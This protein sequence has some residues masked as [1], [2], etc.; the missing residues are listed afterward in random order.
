MCAKRVDTTGTERRRMGVS[1]WSG[2]EAA[3]ALAEQE[4]RQEAVEAAA[5][6]A[7]SGGTAGSAGSGGTAGSAG[8]GGSA[9]SGGT[10][11]SAG[12]GGTAG[13]AGTA[14]S[15]GAGGSGG[16]T[17]YGIEGQS[18]TGM[19]GT[20]CQGVSCCQNILVPGG[21]YPM[22]RSASGTDAYAGQADEQPE[23]DVTVSD[24][25]L[26]TYEVTVGRFRKFVEAFDGTPPSDGAGA[27]PLIVGT[28]WQAAWNANLA[29][30]QVELQSN[31]K[32]SAT[33]QTWT[34]TVGANETYPIN[35]VS[36]YESFA[37]CLWD[38]GRLPT[39][40]EWENAS[41][42][43]AENRLYP[44]GQQAPSAST[45]NFQWIGQFAVHRRGVA[46]S[47]SRSLGSSRPCREHVGVGV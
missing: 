16:G 18:C 7:G 9:G 12:S 24:F 11:G 3:E 1:R 26:D 43:G 8:A 38:G 21:T 37:F 27:H 28:G 6:S 22:G 47:W 10:A 14:G 25:Y 33:Y 15:G 32:C 23:H 17:T 36:W 5:G 40:A 34:D 46:C 41:A 13:S 44:W 20:E 19:T 42:G 35:C 4:A 29:S 2:Q 45:A 39:E 31:V 30:S